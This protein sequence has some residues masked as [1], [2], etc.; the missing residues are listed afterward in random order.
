MGLNNRENEFYERIEHR[1]PDMLKFL[2][3][4]IGVLNV[5]FSKGPKQAAN[6]GATDKSGTN[7]S[8][9]SEVQSADVNR[10][11]L[12]AAGS[13]VT[14]QM[15]Q[16]RIVSHSQQIGSIPQVILE[17]NKHIIPSDYFVLPE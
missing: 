16:P 9:A 7:G 8:D 12:P 14:Q 5:T 3:R 4:Y 17:Q 10:S 2:P 6:S 13:E 15:P 11:D 1:H